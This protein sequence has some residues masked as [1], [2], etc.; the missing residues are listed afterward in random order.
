MNEEPENRDKALAPRDIEHLR[1]M[2]RELFK[3]Q[4]R[5]DA[6]EQ[7]RKQLNTHSDSAERDMTNLERRANPIMR[8]TDRLL[9]RVRTDTTRLK[10]KLE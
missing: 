9:D 1:S 6:L 4:R 7:E 5:L 8:D 3:T 10:Y 2:E